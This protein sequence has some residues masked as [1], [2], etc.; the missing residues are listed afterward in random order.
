MVFTAN[1]ITA[2]FEENGQLAIPAATRAQLAT[3]GFQTGTDLAEFDNKSLKQLTENLRCPGGQI[4]DPN[5]NAAPGA[6]IRTPSFIFGAKSQLRLK[7][8]ITIAKYYETVGRPLTA[9]N[10]RWDPV[11]KNFTEHWKALGERKDETNLETPKISK[12]LTIMKWTEA[13]SDFSRHVIG[14]RTIPLSYVIRAE[15]DVPDAAPPLMQNQPYAE[16]FGSVE[17]ELVARANHTHPLFRE[18]NSALYFFLEEATRGTMYASSIQ[19]FSRRKHGRQAWLALTSQYAGKD[20]WAS[21]LKRQDELI[22]SR[23]WKGQANFSLDKFVSMHRNAYVSMQQCA[24]HVDFQL[25]NQHYRVGFLLDGI[26]TTDASLQAAMALV[27][28]DEG[29]DG[30]RNNF[31]A[32]ACCLLPHDSVAK[33]RRTQDNGGRGRDA[34]ISG[35]NSDI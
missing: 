9:S 29:A 6:M 1:Q 14:S 2:F 4:P 23:K 18:D 28:N 25:P 10:M 33:K 22:H 31:E 30:K 17:E 34:E 27:R 32:T 7:A 26:E 11:I 15:E 24:E 5:P 20:K 3:E 13:F 35:I 19:P 16:E 12:T 21:E 8:A